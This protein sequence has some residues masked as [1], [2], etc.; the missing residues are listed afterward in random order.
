MTF[1]NIF[2]GT[3]TQKLPNTPAVIFSYPCRGSWLIF[4]K[5]IIALFWVIIYSFLLKFF[6]IG[7]YTSKHYTVHRKTPVSESLFDQLV[8]CYFFSERLR[9]RR[10]LMNFAKLSRTPFL[11]NTLRLL[12]LYLWNI[13]V[14]S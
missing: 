6:K 7:I 4:S 11:Q 5:Q 2:A 14:T 1:L 3:A 12:L 10:F 8:A 13:S 9:H